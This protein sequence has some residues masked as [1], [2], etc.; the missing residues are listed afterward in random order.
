[1]TLINSLIIR[2]PAEHC[3]PCW[4][5]IYILQYNLRLHRPDLHVPG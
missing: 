2:F 1:V 4:G 5:R 3:Y